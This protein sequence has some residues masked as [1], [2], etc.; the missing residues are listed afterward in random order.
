MK[1]LL[2]FLIFSFFVTVTLYADY[3][4]VQGVRPVSRLDRLHFKTVADMRNIPQKPSYYA[5]QIVPMKRS[6]QTAYDREYNR[7]YF[8][9][10]SLKKLSE[11]IDKLTWQFRF[12]KRKKIYDSRYRRVKQSTID[13]WIKNSNF[14]ALDSDGRYAITV[15]ESN[16]RSFPTDT[17]AYRDPWKNTEGY[18][19]D[20]FQHS[21]IHIN[22]PL[23]VSHLSKDGKW[24]FVQAAH[25]F[26]WIKVKDIAFTSDKFRRLFRSGKYM[27]TIIDNLY[28][29]KN[30]KREALLKLSTIFPLSRYTKHLLLAVKDKKGYAE[31]V[32]I[33]IPSKP[34][35]AEKPLSFTPHNAAKIAFQLYG[36]P[37]GW[38]GKDYGRDC[39]AMT[40]DF[41]GVFGIFL[42]RNSAEQAKEGK[43]INIKGLKGEAKKRAIL[44]YAKPFRSLL[45]VPGHIVLYIGHYGK[46]PVI[47]HS[48]WGIR[49]KDW[50][51]YPLCRTIITSTSPGD[52]LSNIR[53]KS[54]LSNTLQKIINF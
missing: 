5:S 46:E 14:N 24:A 45:Y 6:I 34:Y 22:T 12:V 10:W 27:V 25:A 21:E 20:Y 4:I 23:F 16:L 19:F 18:P 35:I 17:P 9:P 13:W 44:K 53:K 39:S 1:L 28:L 43:S 38:G 3:Q 7:R 49:Q 11:S 36:E 48:Y 41:L 52:E 2:K 29:I 8:E 37:Y 42:K 47:M 30:G 31:I 40:R 51:K 15:R 54:E 50:S 26:G 32:K 33:P